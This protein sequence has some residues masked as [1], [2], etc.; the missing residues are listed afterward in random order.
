M[1]AVVQENSR[2]AAQKTPVILSVKLAS[3]DL[4]A[5]LKEM[6][7]PPY[8]GGLGGVNPPPNGKR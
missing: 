1:E 6:L 5:A 4:L 7:I 3:I 8:S 2:N